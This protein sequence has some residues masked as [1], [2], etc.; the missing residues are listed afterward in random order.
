MAAEYVMMCSH[1]HLFTL[2]QLLLLVFQIDYDAL[3]Y[4][5]YFNSKY[6]LS[7]KEKRKVNIRMKT[8]ILEMLKDIERRHS[9]LDRY[10]YTLR[11]FVHSLHAVYWLLFKVLHVFGNSSMASKL[12]CHNIQ[13]RPRP[14]QQNLELFK[15]LVVFTQIQIQMIGSIVWRKL[16]PDFQDTISRISSDWQNF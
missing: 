4:P 8:T 2:F 7:C 12:N 9:C 1:M 6:L 10:W 11:Y 16:N 13:D 5:C 3:L 14:I 15:E